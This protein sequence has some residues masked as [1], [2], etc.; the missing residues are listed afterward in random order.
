MLLYLRQ[1]LLRKI[2]QSTLVTIKNYTLLPKML[3]MHVFLLCLL[4]NS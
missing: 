3:H 4:F 2:D 1:N